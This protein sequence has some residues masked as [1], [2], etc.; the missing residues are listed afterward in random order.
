MILRHLGMASGRDF[1]PINDTLTRIVLHACNMICNMNF[2]ASMR[3]QKALM[4]FCYKI[5]KK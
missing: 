5:K 4:I 3:V 2:A 1:R